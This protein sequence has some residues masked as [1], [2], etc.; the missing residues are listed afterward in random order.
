MILKSFKGLAK[1]SSLGGGHHGLVVY[2]DASLQRGL[3][4]ETWQGQIHFFLW[5]ELEMNLKQNSEK[6]WRWYWCS[7][8]EPS[9][10]NSN[11][12]FQRGEQAVAVKM[13]TGCLRKIEKI[14]IY[15]T[16]YGTK[17]FTFVVNNM[18]AK[19]LPLEE[20]G[21]NMKTLLWC[22]NLIWNIGLMATKRAP[23][24]GQIK[25]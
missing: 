22:T 7:T 14:N 5:A 12:L 17:A 1:S 3:Q 15:F 16:S 20:K 10:N 11:C 9:F 8:T 25:K 18:E 23:Y 6:M 24:R 21:S 13:V 19:I 4:L 2:I